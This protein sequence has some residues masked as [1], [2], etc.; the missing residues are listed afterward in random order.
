MEELIEQLEAD[1]IFGLKAP[2]TAL[3]WTAAQI[4]AFFESDG[5]IL[6]AETREQ[7]TGERRPRAKLAMPDAQVCEL[8]EALVAAYEDK[9]LRERVAAARSSGK[10]DAMQLVGAIALVA[11]EPILRRYGFQVSADGVCDMK[12]TVAHSIYRGNHAARA[13]ADKAKTLLGFKPQYKLKSWECV[14]SEHLQEIWSLEESVGAHPALMDALLGIDTPQGLEEAALEFI[15]S[16]QRSGVG[17]TSLITYSHYAR[18]KLPLGLWGVGAS[19]VDRI[20]SPTPEELSWFVERNVPVVIEGA[21]DAVNSPLLRDLRDCE[22]L[23]SRYGDRMVKVKVRENGIHQNMYCGGPALHLPF[24][25]WLDQLERDPED[26]VY[27]AAKMPL[28]QELP[29]LAE[30][31]HN[32]PSSPA[33]IFGECFGRVIPEGVH[34]YFGAGGQTTNTHYD[35]HENLCLCVKGTKRFQLFPPSNTE[36]L[37]PIKAPGY[38]LSAVLP[39]QWVD[40]ALSSSAELPQAI[41]TPEGWK[42]FRPIVEK[43]TPIEVEIKAGEILYLPICWWHGVT[44]GNESNMILNWWLGMHPTKQYATVDHAQRAI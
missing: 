19:S 20:H 7:S 5:E 24:R 14:I 29:E 38:S 40:G 33:R 17:I 15:K 44:A 32:E 28:R 13:L 27:Y 8:C 1:S 12:E 10:P 37:M 36:L 35:P 4:E 30:L 3:S 21:L 42:P 16:K 2:E 26:V 18:M 11:Q 9:E 41:P 25:H 6:P 34:M 43:C 31:I 22:Y 39:F 23:R